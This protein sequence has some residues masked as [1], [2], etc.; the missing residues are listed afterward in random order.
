MVNCINPLQ[1]Q[2]PSTATIVAAAEEEEEEEQG[3]PLRTSLTHSPPLVL[4]S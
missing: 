4:N 3:P 2:P 1:L